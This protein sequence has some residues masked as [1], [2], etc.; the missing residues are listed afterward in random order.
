[1]PGAG[2]ARSFT[3]FHI[4]LGLAALFP[5]AARSGVGSLGVRSGVV[6]VSFASGTP[7]VVIVSN[8]LAGGSAA[9]R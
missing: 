5:W 6:Y 3:L 4:S 9:P 8:T 7:T 1:M 2:S